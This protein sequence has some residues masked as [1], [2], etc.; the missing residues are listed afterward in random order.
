MKSVLASVVA[1]D[2]SSYRRPGVRM[3]ILENNKMI[4]AVSGGCVEKKI[5][6]QSQSVFKTGQSKVMTYNGRYRLCCEGIL[7]ILI[8]PFNPNVK[9]VNAFTNSLDNRETFE[10]ISYYDKREGVSFDFGSYLKIDNEMFPVDGE[11]IDNKVNSLSLFEQELPPCFKL[12][13]IGA[14][15]DAVQLCKYASLTGWEVTVI[16]GVV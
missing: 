6:F 15:N 3:L 12:L 9:F 4:G 16:A 13:I 8:E 11:H 2:G 10:L 1:L 5:L 14:E 7:Y